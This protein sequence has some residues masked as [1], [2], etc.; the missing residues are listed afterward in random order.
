MD[1]AVSVAA[2]LRRKWPHIASAE[3]WGTAVGRPRVRGRAGYMVSARHEQ[4]DPQHLD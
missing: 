1:V 3:V 4:L 2:R